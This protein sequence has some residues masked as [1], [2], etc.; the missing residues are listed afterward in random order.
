MTINADTTGSR[1]D[2]HEPGWHSL[3]VAICLN[4]LQDYWTWHRGG[5]IKDMSFRPFTSDK[6]FP[7]DVLDLLRFIKDGTMAKIF[8][9]VGVDCTTEELVRRLRRMEQDGSH[10]AMF[11]SGRGRSIKRRTPPASSTIMRTSQTTPP[12]PARARL[13]GHASPARGY[14]PADHKRGRVGQQL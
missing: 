11:G 3:A 12:T 7:C 5:A 14:R 6:F 2:T 8:D 13:A 1:T 4:A 9:M 10:K